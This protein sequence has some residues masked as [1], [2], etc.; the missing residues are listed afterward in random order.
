MNKYDAKI[1]FFTFQ[2]S[3]GHIQPKP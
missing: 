1:V 2:N 3:I